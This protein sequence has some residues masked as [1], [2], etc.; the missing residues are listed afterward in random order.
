MSDF[1]REKICFYTCI[2]KGQHSLYQTID[3]AARHGVNGVE[4][5]N[6]GVEL[7]TPDM[8]LA[9]EIGGYAKG[10]GLT[11][12]CF[13]CAVDFYNDQKTNLNYMHVYVDICSEL[14]IPYLHHT[15]IPTLKFA[16][17]ENDFQHRM[18]IAVE[19]AL[20]LNAYAKSKGVK[21]LVEEQGMVVNGTDNYLEFMKRTEG[22]IGFV[23]DTGNI[24]F[25]DEHPDVFYKNIGIKAD[26]VH[27]KDYIVADEPIVE[28]R[29]VSKG[30]KYLYPADL[31]DGVVKFDVISKMLKAQNYDGHISFEFRPFNNDEEIAKTLKKVCEI[32][33]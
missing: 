12:P 8:K 4:L 19:C 6:F 3:T 13:T 32:F 30:G 17:V 5:I 28:I 26:H 23:L 14:E 15:L 2:I 7:K 11:I 16:E 22:K 18:D 20:E 27:I 29:S 24:F 25:V 31:G 9:K 21:T 1:A 33:E 10:K